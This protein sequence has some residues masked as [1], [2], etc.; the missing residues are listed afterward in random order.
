[1][2][3]SLTRF[4]FKILKNPYARDPKHSER[5]IIGIIDYR[6]TQALLLYYIGKRLLL[7]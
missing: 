3:L 5:G 6:Y 7:T 1:M 4:A 2:I